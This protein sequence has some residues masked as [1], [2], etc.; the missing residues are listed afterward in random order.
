MTIDLSG[1]GAAIDPRL[2]AG[3]SSFAPGSSAGSSAGS[4]VADRQRDFASLISRQ[5][6][7]I[8]PGAD[9][10]EERARATAQDFVATS[11]LE[12]LLRSVREANQAPAPWGPSDVEKRFGGLIDAE[13]ARNIVRSSNLG[14]VDRLARDLL[15]ASSEQEVMDD[16]TTGNAAF[17]GTN[18]T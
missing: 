9:T 8:D 18:A 10:P 11:L 17:G 5:T 16:R 2:R 1:F 15:R 4:L 12:P 6:A 13:Q 7:G 14:I 3:G